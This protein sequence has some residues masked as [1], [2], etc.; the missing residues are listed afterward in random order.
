[1]KTLFNRNTGIAAFAAV[2]I[3]GLTGLMLD[4]GHAGALPQGVIEIGELEAV[5]VGDLNIAT[6]PAIE[7][8]GQR[9]VQFADAAGNADT[10]G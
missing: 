7:V 6:L 2:V 3:V 1:M 4:R 10:Q 5:M 9:A 8:I